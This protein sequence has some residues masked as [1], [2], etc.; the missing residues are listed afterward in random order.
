MSKYLKVPLHGSPNTPLLALPSHVRC[1]LQ[2][3][4]TT[5]RESSAAQELVLI[6]PS[7]QIDDV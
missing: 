4:R 3:D 6:G 1:P 2:F 5:A 7:G